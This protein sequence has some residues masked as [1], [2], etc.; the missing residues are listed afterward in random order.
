VLWSFDGYG[1]ISSEQRTPAI[2]EFDPQS[3]HSLVLSYL[4]SGERESGLIC[5]VAAG[6][7]ICK[8]HEKLYSPSLLRQ[9]GFNIEDLVDRY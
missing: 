2:R 9:M 3:K 1:L 5:S 4:E 7:S 8:D 6:V